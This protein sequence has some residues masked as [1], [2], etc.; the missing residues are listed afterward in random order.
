MIVLAVVGVAL[1]IVGSAGDNNNGS[2]TPR[3][4]PASTKHHKHHKHQ[5]GAAVKHHPAPP[6]SVRLSLVPTGAVYVCLVN[7]HGHA[8]INGQQYDAGQ[9]IPVQVAHTLLLTLGT[10]SV[11]ITANGVKV[12]VAP[13]SSPI[14]IRFTPGKHTS[15]ASGNQPPCS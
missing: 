15:L 1:W 10:N 7:G 3:T 4:S 9:K 14:G 5:H 6:K 2:T 12:P 11:T 8:L 13:S